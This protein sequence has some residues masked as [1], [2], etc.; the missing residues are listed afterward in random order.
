MYLIHHT[1]VTLA[2]KGGV[3]QDQW[4]SKLPRV[5]EFPFSSERKRM[6]VI[7]QVEDVDTGVSPFGDVDPLL[8]GLVTSESH[9]MFTKGSP[10]LILARCSHNYTGESSIPLDEGQRAS[11][12]AENDRMASKGLRVLGFAYKPLTEVPPEDGAEQQEQKLVWLGLVGM[13]FGQSVQPTIARLNQHRPTRLRHNCHCP[14]G[15]CQGLSRNPTRCS[16]MAKNRVLGTM[17]QPL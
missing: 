2:A 12:V 7:C 16:R 11:I 1:I 8:K 6:S 13:L 9:I 17:Q 10:E 3:E 15:C 5:G 14:T 4:N